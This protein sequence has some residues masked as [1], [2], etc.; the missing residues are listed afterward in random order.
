MAMEFVHM[1]NAHTYLFAPVF[2]KREKRSYVC[3]KMYK[4]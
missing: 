1:K 3:D 4:L 2:V